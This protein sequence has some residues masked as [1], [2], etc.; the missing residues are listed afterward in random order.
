MLWKWSKTKR[1]RW[2]LEGVLGTSL[3]LQINAP[4]AESVFESCMARIDELEEI[5]S[6][7]RTTSEFSRFLSSEGKSVP[8]SDELAH[9]LKKAAEWR[10][11]SGG[12]FD[13]SLGEHPINKEIWTIAGSSGVCHT[14]AACTLNAIAKGYIVDQI[15]EKAIALGATEVLVNIG[16]DLRHIGP[17]PVVIGIANP[18]ADNLKPLAAIKLLNQGM[19]TSGGAFRTDGT[20]EGSH[21]INPQDKK[22]I[23]R[24]IWCSCVA[25]SCFEADFAAT[26]LTVTEGA[27]IP[28]NITG[29]EFVI[30]SS[31]GELKQSSGWSNLLKSK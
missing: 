29:L 7:Y 11:Q 10:Q 16:G 20:E 28:L 1:R 31:D 24:K 25:Q 6:S 8:L 19:A 26:I 3:D 12:V 15:A 23:S 9:V 27:M 4:D 13:P 14:S 17:K 2:Q 21:I 30:T 5:F 22:G 18:M